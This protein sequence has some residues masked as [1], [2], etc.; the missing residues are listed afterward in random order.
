VLEN[1]DVFPLFTGGP[2]D[3][4]Y[5]QGAR[6]VFGKQVFDDRFEPATLPVWARIAARHCADCSIYPTFSVGHEMYTPQ[7]IEVAEPQPGEHPW[8]AWLYGA[9]GST[10]DAPGG[11]R[12]EYQLQLGVTGDPAGG[13]QLQDFWHR[14]INRP[15]AAGWDNQLGSDVGINAYY[16][17]RRISLRSAD[18]S[19][20]HWD[21]GPTVEAAFGTMHTYASFGGMARIGRHAGD[22][23]DPLLEDAVERPLWPVSLDRV[24]IY[25]FLGA[26]IRI[27]GYNYFLEGSRFHDDPYTVERENVVQE[28]ILGVSARYKGWAVSYTIHRRSEEFKRLV[29]ED[30]GRHSFGSLRI[31]RGFD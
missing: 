25:G 22:V 6:F 21:F 10:V 15:R 11:G 28:L 20:V 24:R 13:Q 26:N 14:L 23:L 31:S 5:S 29:G 4:F 1:D 12:H 18:N 9:V 27:V 19:R 17:F 2:S 7:L 30:S 16:G 8:A 3:R